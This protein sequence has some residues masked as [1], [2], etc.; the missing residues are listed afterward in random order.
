MKRS[1]IKLDL[2]PTR[3]YSYYSEE[4]RYWVHIEAKNKHE[5]LQKARIYDPCTSASELYLLKING[6]YV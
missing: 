1:V 6:R 2:R 5:A 3:T 4:K